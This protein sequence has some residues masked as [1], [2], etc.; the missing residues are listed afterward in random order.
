MPKRRGALHTSQREG[1]TRTMV[2]GELEPRGA[3]QGEG[4]GVCCWMWWGC[5]H[6]GRFYLQLEMR[7]FLMLCLGACVG[8]SFFKVIK[9]VC[10]SLLFLFSG[11]SSRNWDGCNSLP[12]GYLLGRKLKQSEGEFLLSLFIKSLKLWKRECHASWG[13]AGFSLRAGRE[14]KQVPLD[15]ERG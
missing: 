10:C 11:I 2:W 6:E 14:G 7:P 8:E 12:W 5:F 13:A 9:P 3:Q 15:Q 1:A 4:P